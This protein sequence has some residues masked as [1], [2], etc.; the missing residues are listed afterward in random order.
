M[1][2]LNPIIVGSKMNS[3][4]R[5]GLSQTLISLRYCSPGILDEKFTLM[6]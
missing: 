3:D 4:L 1:K 6:K 5:V 2:I